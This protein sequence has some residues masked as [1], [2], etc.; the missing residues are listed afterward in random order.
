MTANFSIY[1]ARNG[2]I[3]ISSGSR[4]TSLTEKQ[5]IE[6]GIMIYDLDEFDYELYMKAYEA[7]RGGR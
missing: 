7:E 2:L 4:F 3:Y 1:Q 6:L 5:V